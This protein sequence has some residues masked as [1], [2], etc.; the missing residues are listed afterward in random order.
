MV[1]TGPSESSLG[2][3]TALFLAP[4]SPKLI[5][6]A[7]RTLSKIQPVIDQIKEINPDVA[8]EFIKLDL[9]SQASVRKAAKEISARVDK[10]DIL[11]NNAGG[12]CYF[13]YVSIQILIVTFVYSHGRKKLH[14][15]RRGHRATI[16]HQPYRPL[17]AHES[18][19]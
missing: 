16:W 13:L 11:I 14:D 10:V 9:A 5:I 15:Y 17:P 3:Q 8:V 1:I 12:M 4:A 19:G 7:G 6:L 2:A 18:P